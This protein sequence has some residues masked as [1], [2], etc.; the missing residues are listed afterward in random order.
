MKWKIDD[1]LLEICIKMYCKTIDGK[2]YFQT[3]GL[4]IGKSKPLAGIHI[5]WFENKYVFGN[6]NTFKHA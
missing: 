6:N 5:H 3:D 2:I 1:K 4:P